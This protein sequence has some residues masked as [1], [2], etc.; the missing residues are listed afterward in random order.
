MTTFTGKVVEAPPQESSRMDI[1]GN[2]PLRPWK[3]G[4]RFRRGLLWRWRA[5]RVQN[6]E[7][8]RRALYKSMALMRA[9]IAS[10]EGSGMAWIARNVGPLRG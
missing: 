8:G 10:V 2:I 3:E 5:V 4:S 7:F 6:R 9:R 1:L